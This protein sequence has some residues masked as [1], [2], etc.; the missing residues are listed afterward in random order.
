MD[1]KKDNENIDESSELLEGNN[2]DATQEDAIYDDNPEEKYT[3]E[4]EG[5]IPEEY[6]LEDDSLR[7]VDYNRGM[8]MEKKIMIAASIFLGV[9]VIAVAV[10]FANQKGFFDKYKKQPGMSITELGVAVNVNDQS[11]SDSQ[12]ENESEEKIE[13]ENLSKNDEKFTPNRNLEIT[14]LNGGGGAG[15]AGK[16]K[17]FLQK[18]GYE[19]ITAKNANEFDHEGVE[20]Y[21]AGND[22]KKDAEAIKKVIEKSY[23]NVSVALASSGDEKLSEI[24]VIVGK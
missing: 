2:P 18:D 15:T 16:M 4:N 14:T 1:L 5:E 11:N 23:D 20:I 21:Y 6:S 8:S 12:K 10:F 3:K 13:N 17:T 22:L 24:V 19:D 9:A 7:I